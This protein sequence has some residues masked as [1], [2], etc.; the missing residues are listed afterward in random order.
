MVHSKN[1]P[2]ANKDR[3]PKCYFGTFELPEI[4][5]LNS[6]KFTRT[7]KRWGFLGRICIFRQQII[8]IQLNLN[9]QITRN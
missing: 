9:I 8:K 2:S 1:N 5:Y 3:I 4:K 6:I 7:L